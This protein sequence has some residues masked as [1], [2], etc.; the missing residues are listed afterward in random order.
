MLWLSPDDLNQDEGEATTP[1]GLPT[2]G[3]AVWLGDLPIQSSAASLV[4]L[5]V[6]GGGLW[7]CGVLVLDGDVSVYGVPGGVQNQ[8]ESALAS[9]TKTD[10]ADVL[11]Q[12]RDW[13]SL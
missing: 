6:Q 4:A 10:P 3:L 9:S 13:A 11:S 8:T 5:L 2:Q 12:R 7:A 1:D